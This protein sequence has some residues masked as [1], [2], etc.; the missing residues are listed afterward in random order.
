M[1]NCSLGGAKSLMARMMNMK[2]VMIT[3]MAAITPVR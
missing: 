3:N 2:V 1:Y